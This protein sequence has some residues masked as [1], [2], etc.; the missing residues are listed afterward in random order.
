M[1]Q[2]TMMAIYQIKNNVNDKVYIGSSSN[3]SLRWKQH[4]DLL[5]YKLH[6]NYK[7]QNDFDK[8]GISNFS[9]SI[10]EIIKD[11]KDLLRKEQ[12]WIDSININE[13]YNILSYSNFNGAELT[14]DSYEIINYKVDINT[15]NLLKE[16]IIVCIHKINSIGEKQT[17]LSKGWFNKSNVSDIK[18]LSNNIKNYYKNI[19]KDKNFYW[20]TFIA[21]QRK[22]ASSGTT[23]KYIGF[24][25]IPKIKYNTLAFCANCFP[26]K[27]IQRN[28]KSEMEIKDDVFALNMLLKWIIN[29]SDISKSINIYIPSQRMR[30]ILINWLDNENI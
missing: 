25:D 13:N 28:L 18:Q 8:Y 23:R 2:K 1:I 17:S 24:N 30:N 7:L 26:N 3:I 29:V 9:F 21:Y 12:N 27:T 14:K 19:A 6:D 11:K 22:L 16:N 10:L 4:L 20:T 5:Y 15:K